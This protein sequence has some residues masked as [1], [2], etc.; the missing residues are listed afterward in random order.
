MYRGVDGRLP[1]DRGAMVKILSDAIDRFDGRDDVAD[2]D[3]L[4][5]RGLI[6]NL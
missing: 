4:V 5:K 3:T 1:A 6:A 2:A